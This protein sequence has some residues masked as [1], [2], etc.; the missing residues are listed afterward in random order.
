MKFLYSINKNLNIDSSQYPLIK[1]INNLANMKDKINDKYVITNLERKLDGVPVLYING[2][3]LHTGDTHNE[4][5]A[6]YNEDYLQYTNKWIFNLNDIEMPINWDDCVQLNIPCARLVL[7]SNNICELLVLYA[8]DTYEISQAVSKKLNC[9]V[10]SYDSSI[11]LFIRTANEYSTW[12]SSDEYTGGERYNPTPQD[13]LNSHQELFDNIIKPIE[14]EIKQYLFK[15]IKRLMTAKVRHYLHKHK[16]FS[17]DDLYNFV[18]KHINF[19][20]IL[21]SI[22]W[23]FI[24]YFDNVISEEQLQFDFLN[25]LKYHFSLYIRLLINKYQNEIIL[26]R[27]QQ[28]TDTNY[29]NDPYIKT[30][31]QLAEI[32]DNVGDTIQLDNGFN[33]NYKC[34]DSAFIFVRGEAFTGDSHINLMKKYM[35]KYNINDPYYFNIEN[36]D[37]IKLPYSY[38]HIYRGKAL[39]NWYKYCTTEEIKNALLKRGKYHVYDYN[40]NKQTLYRL[41]HLI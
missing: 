20:S 12:I 39:I 17:N 21:E 10:Y 25:Y 40:I 16:E 31:E 4:L 14:P 23:D 27:E 28:L 24:D 26:T 22:E 18:M 11:N 19:T 30:P 6:S 5:F 34:R 33:I 35:K 3:I 36:I 1:S 2:T 37:K 32:I 8:G 7:Y 15:E 13:I 38:G 29:L 41:A 9:K